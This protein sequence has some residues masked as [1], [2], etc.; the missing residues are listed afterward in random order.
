MM[1]NRSAHILLACLLMFSAF[2]SFAQVNA[3][4]TVDKDRILIGEPIKLTLQ[5]YAPLGQD[6]SWFALDTIPRFEF[7]SK[8][9]ID[10]TETVDGKKLEQ[11]LVITSFDSGSIVLPPLAIAAGANTFFTDSIAIEVGYT[12]FNPEEEYRD[13][14]DIEEVFNPLAKYIPWIVTAITVLS[15]GGVAWFLQKRKKVVVEKKILASKLTPIEE[16]MQALDKLK[17]KDTS[18]LEAVKAYYTDLNDVLRI[19]VFRKLSISSL[20][21]TNE[22]LILSLKDHIPHRDSFSKLAQALRMSDFVKFAKY[23][24][25]AADNENNLE[26]IRAA[27]KTLDQQTKTE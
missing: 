4:A 8:S 20:E 5:V 2:S 23:Q 16:A 14:K 13:I 24:P 22:E 7:I 3:K 18:D 17:K 11:Q 9:K 12:K 10:S 6:F 26:T 1:K 25:P 19:F 21:R 15:L 27:I